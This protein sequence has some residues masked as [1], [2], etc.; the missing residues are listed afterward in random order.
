MI[1]EQIVEQSKIVECPS[2]VVDS[3]SKHLRPRC[4][5][6]KMQVFSKLGAW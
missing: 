1:A 5:P 3:G 4:L 6:I 2:K